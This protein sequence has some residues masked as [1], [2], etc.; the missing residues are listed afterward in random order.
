MRR[1]D[2]DTDEMA[3]LMDQGLSWAQIGARL[4]I[5]AN[6]ACRRAR[7]LGI[8][9]TVRV[10]GRPGAT[11]DA[12]LLA[13]MAGDGSTWA[14]I[15]DALGVTESIAYRAALRLNIVKVSRRGTGGRDGRKP[16]YLFDDISRARLTQL[17]ERGLGWRDIARAIGGKC[18]ARHCR[19]E[20]IRMGVYG[21]GGSVAAPRP[22]E[23]PP[24]GGQMS[25]ASVRAERRALASL[26]RDWA[27]KP[28]EPRL[29]GV[30]GRAA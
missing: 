22:V 3:R 15:A 18:H 13:R 17:I 29:V 6:L 5:K 26:E 12:E 20:A 28:H 11:V 14:Q 2:F 25:A 4:G 30:K 8:K 10:A 27:L 23:R 1:I 7:Q 16:H 9:R 24:G 19:R 21:G